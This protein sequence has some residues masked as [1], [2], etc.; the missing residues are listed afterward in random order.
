M[1]SIISSAIEEICFHGQGGVSLSSLCSK[2]DIPPSLK[3]S[4]WRNLLSIPALRFKPRNAE[5]LSSS[6][7]SI[8]CVEDA[9]KLDVKIL[10]DEKL[11]NN[12]V[13]L[14]DEN[15]QI[16]SQQRRTLERLAIARFG[17]F[18]YLIFVT[19][20][21]LKLLVLICDRVLKIAHD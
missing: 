3:S 5:F 12:F 4:L 19:G 1:D 21:F 7:A 8:Q 20:Y 14:Y 9:E 18:D 6:D 15:V 11:R 17:F 10:A 2:L 16:S 13:G